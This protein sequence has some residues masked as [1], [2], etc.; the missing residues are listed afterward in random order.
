MALLS[1]FWIDGFCFFFWLM[2]ACF[3]LFFGF[4]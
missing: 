4:G 1:F 3:G 2:A